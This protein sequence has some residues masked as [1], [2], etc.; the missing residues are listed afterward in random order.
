MARLQDF[1]SV[2]PSSS[3]N[4]L[5]VQPTGQGLASFGSTI[6]NKAPK[7][8]LASI[9]ITGST[10]NTGST[11]KDAT[12]FYLNGNLVRAKGDILNGATLTANT[13]YIYVN[14][15][16]GLNTRHKWILINNNITN[17]DNVQLTGFDEYL[18]LLFGSGVQM[19]SMIVVDDTN[20][21]SLKFIAS[22]SSQKEAYYNAVNH[23]WS[24]T[25][26]YKAI[27]YGKR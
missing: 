2:T 27:L 15:V 5:I 8:D 18:V 19:G 25:S 11:I 22:D 13:N 3:D 4:L 26:G 9:S 21:F 10:N 23:N 7:T 12:F 14:V 1:Q 16:G 24:V 6:G 20:N 17:G